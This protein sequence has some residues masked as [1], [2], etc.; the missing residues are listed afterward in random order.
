MLPICFWDV[1]PI[2]RRALTV[3]LLHPMVLAT[4]NPPRPLSPR[5]TRLRA[6]LHDYHR[7]QAEVNAA[8]GPVGPW[9]WLG[10]N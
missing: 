2:P 7:T 5:A 10:P 6:T 4:A 8:T 1:M 9:P 3:R